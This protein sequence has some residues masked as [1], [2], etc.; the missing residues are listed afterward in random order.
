MEQVQEFKIPE[1]CGEWKR[2]KEGRVIM[3]MNE[4]KVSGAIEAL[5]NERRLSRAR[6]SML[7]E[8]IEREREKERE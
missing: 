8:S 2:Y 6:E 1:M 3:G 7:H 4:R 5:V